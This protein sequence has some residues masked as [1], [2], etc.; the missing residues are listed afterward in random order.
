M[1]EVEAFRKERDEAIKKADNLARLVEEQEEDFVHKAWKIQRQAD[2]AEALSR[3]TYKKQIQTN[4][5]IF[6]LLVCFWLLCL[7]VI[8]L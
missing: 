7:V 4:L 2:V 5:L 1:M 8:C 6:G 3:K